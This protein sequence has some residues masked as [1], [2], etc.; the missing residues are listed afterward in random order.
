MSVDP[1]TERPLPVAFAF[2]KLPAHG[3]FISRGLD[4]A[5][6][7]AGDAAVANAVALAAERWDAAWDDVYV[8]TPVWRFVASPG[9]IGQEWA[10]G[11]FMASVDAVGRQFP[12][13]AGFAA[14][15]LALVGRPADTAAAVER[16]ESVCRDA[17]V[18]GL[19][20]DVVMERL[21]AAVD[22]TF[23]ATPPDDPVV[24]FAGG[25][26][27]QL[28]AKPWTPQSVWWV[29]GARETPLRLEGP[30]SGE[31]LVPLFRRMEAQ[32]E[33]EP[34]S[35]LAEL[36]IVPVEAA[37]N[38]PQDNAAES[39]V[40]SSAADETVKSGGADEDAEIPHGA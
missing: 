1:L 20:I 10:A 5:A 18:E 31:G 28:D 17:L 40:S 24:A 3:D 35:A 26:L 33:P 15:S 34:D 14:P 39:V 30:L 37:A 22:D 7:E 4:D 21:S 32:A 36:E 38:P 27:S 19:S 13:V 9:V 29:A 2:G 25:L 16:V 12:L 23:G 11:A 6:V 8:E